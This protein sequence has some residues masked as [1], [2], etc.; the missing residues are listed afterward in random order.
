MTLPNFVNSSFTNASF[1][2]LSYIM[3]VFRYHIKL[4]MIVRSDNKKYHH[5]YIYLSVL[6]YLGIYP[7][8]IY[9]KRICIGH[10]VGI[11]VLTKM[12]KGPLDIINAPTGI[13][14]IKIKA[15]DEQTK[16]LEGTYLSRLVIVN[17][18]LCLGLFWLPILYFLISNAYLNLDK[19]FV[20][21]DRFP[22]LHLSSKHF[23]YPALS[24]DEVLTP[25]KKKRHISPCFIPFPPVS[26][27]F[28][29]TL[30][31]T[32]GAVVDDDN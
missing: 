3:K 12:N 16:K 28:P 25:P 15:R 6:R 24:P 8:R 2:N 20:L 27:L 11:S 21:Y 1:I 19:L 17:V 31:P 32:K 30:P 9:Q 22:K 5:K 26:T 7:F 29:A 13:S 18:G 23:H 10:N 14:F 4:K